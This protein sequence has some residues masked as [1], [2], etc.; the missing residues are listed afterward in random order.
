MAVAG[1]EGTFVVE[2]DSGG[3]EAFPRQAG[4][5]GGAAQLIMRAPELGG[6]YRSLSG[7]L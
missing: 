5:P 1:G 3:G 2:V 4:N 7:G 6:H